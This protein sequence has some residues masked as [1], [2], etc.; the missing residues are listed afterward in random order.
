MATNFGNS[1]ENSFV[2]KLEVAVF[3]RF[4]VLDLVVFLKL[5]QSRVGNTVKKNNDELQVQNKF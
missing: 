4:P 2:K 5:A 3:D 1:Q